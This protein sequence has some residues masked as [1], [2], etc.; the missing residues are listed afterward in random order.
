MK[1]ITII[2]I[3]TILVVMVHFNQSDST[4]SKYK[5]LREE[6]LRQ[7][8][9]LM[10]NKNKNNNNT[11]VPA[12]TKFLVISSGRSGTTSLFNIL[13][14]HREVCSFREIFQKKTPK[15][16]IESLEI[17]CE[18]QQSALAH[19]FKALYSQLTAHF[20]QNCKYCSSGQYFPPPDPSPIEALKQ[21]KLWFHAP[22]LKVIHLKRKDLFASALS[23]VELQTHTYHDANQAS[24]MP[25]R[26]SPEHVLELAEF[27][28][29][30]ERLWDS[31]LRSTHTPSLIVFSDDIKAHPEIYIAQIYDFLGL[32]APRSSLKASQTTS[33]ATNIDYRWDLDHSSLP[34]AER[35][36]NWEELMAFKSL[37]PIYVRSLSNSTAL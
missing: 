35:F 37:H 9:L 15:I 21:I 6:L 1:L 16:S 2:I 4:T 32:S 29:S 34:P 18:S 19:G 13:S 33:Q 17:M 5:N 24:M 20:P 23:R 36:T 26:I 22:D 8:H 12:I 7:S 10:K 3:I 27:F 11:K 30:Q 14:N 25:I 28:L 31:I